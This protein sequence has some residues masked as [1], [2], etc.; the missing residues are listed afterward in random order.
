MSKKDNKDRVFKGMTAPVEVN[1]EI[2][3]VEIWTY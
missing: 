1:F 2:P 3:D